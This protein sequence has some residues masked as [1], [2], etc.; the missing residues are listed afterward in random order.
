MSE[1]RGF[2]DDMLG[3]VTRK[4]INGATLANIKL[5]KPAAIIKLETDMKESRISLNLMEGFPLSASKILWMFNFSTFMTTCKVLE[6]KFGW[7]TS[8]KQ[9]MVAM[10]KWPKAER[11]KGSLC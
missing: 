8:L 6:K 11:P 5:I 4:I 10:S 9:C 1:T 7:K 3:T 2:T